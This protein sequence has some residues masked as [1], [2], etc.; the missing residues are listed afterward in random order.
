MEVPAEPINKSDFLKI[1]I[2]FVSPE[3]ILMNLS[4]EYLDLNFKEF[5]TKGPSTIF[6]L[7]FL[8]FFLKN[9]FL[10]SEDRLSK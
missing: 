9:F 3:M 7:K 8:I 4:L 2:K 6:I 5:K 1:L 10:I